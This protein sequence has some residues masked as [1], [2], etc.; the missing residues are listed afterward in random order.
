LGKQPVR[1]MQA[2]RRSD[3]ATVEVINTTDLTA[4]RTTDYGG[5]KQM[6]NDDTPGPVNRMVVGAQDGLV[7]WIHVPLA[8]DTVDMV[9]H[10][11]PLQRV[12]GPGQ[13]LYEINE[14]HHIHLI[15]WMKHLSYKKQDTETFDAKASMGAR[16]NFEAYCR[17]VSLEG[18]RIKHKTR[19][20][21]YGGI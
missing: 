3:N 8:D 9:V 10:R 17:Q 4:S 18:E 14:I 13:Q 5:L 19:V 1:I 20:V 12:T 7:R 11:L 16:A 15:D 2:K 21:G 6:L